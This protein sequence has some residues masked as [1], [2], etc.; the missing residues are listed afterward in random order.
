MIFGI[1]ICSVIEQVFTQKARADKKIIEK[2][3]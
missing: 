2:G 1:L 3:P